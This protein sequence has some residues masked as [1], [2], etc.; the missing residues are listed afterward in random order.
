MSSLKK[1][2]SWL[3]LLQVSSYIFPIITTPYLLRTLGTNNYGIYAIFL[4]YFQYMYMVIDFGYNLTA[5]REVAEV[6]DNDNKK[7]SYILSTVFLAKTILVL[8]MI[9]IS[10][11]IVLY[12]YPSYLNLYLI[13][14]VG[15]ISNAYYTN[16]LYQGLERLK[17]VSVVTII[18]KFVVFS[19]TLIFV[20]SKADI[21]SALWIY[22][23]SFM[24]PTLVLLFHS[25]VFLQ[26]RIHKVKFTYIIK[27][28]K[29]SMPIF[30]SNISTSLYTSLNSVVLSRYASV[31]IV[32]MYYSADRIR[33][34]L[35]SLLNPISQAVYPRICSEKDN[36]TFFKRFSIVFILSGLLLTISCALFSVFFGDR[37]FGLESHQAS[38][39]LLAMSP[40]LF[41]I[42][43]AVVFGQWFMVARG[44][45][46]KFSRI[47]IV[48]SLL[49]V[50]IV[51]PLVHSFSVW[52][53][54]MSSTF[55][56]LSISLSMMFFYLREKNAKRNNN[57]P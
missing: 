13:S 33:V 11:L 19:A 52:G 44:Y 17:F 29:H 41:I 26:L 21:S 23:I 55:T 14:C 32:G 31:D 38:F 16:W 25:C 54:I 46:K 30:T 49:H 15:L 56:Q 6:K 47:Y 18:T 10:G 36:S 3:F 39:Y 22:S 34:A 37:Y 57:T 27:S 40:L 5:T 7:L 43:L 2:V 35:Q 28:L 9:L 45:T 1:N 51:F 48:F 8:I 4:V 42:S 53:I 24:L 12:F 50:C 20:K